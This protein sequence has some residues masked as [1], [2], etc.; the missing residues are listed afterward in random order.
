MVVS[1]GLVPR[2]GVKCLQ[3]C[4]LGALQFDIVVLKPNFHFFSFFALSLQHHGNVKHTVFQVRLRRSLH[5]DTL[6]ASGRKV[7]VPS[8]PTSRHGTYRESQAPA[9]P[10]QPHGH[11]GGPSQL[12]GYCKIGAYVGG[13]GRSVFEEVGNA[14]LSARKDNV[15][16]LWLCKCL[17]HCRNVATSCGMDLSHL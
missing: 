4:S 15:R 5:R 6:F 14:A 11:R 7:S 9:V 17:G 1:E 13:L 3:V 16:P 8:R 12:L 2:F 10:A